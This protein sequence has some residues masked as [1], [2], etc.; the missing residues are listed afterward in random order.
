MKICR[1]ASSAEFRAAWA[2]ASVA[3]VRRRPA[4]SQATLSATSHSLRPE[5]LR[6]AAIVAAAREATA[7]AATEADET[8]L[9]ARLMALLE[10]SGGRRLAESVQVAETPATVMEPA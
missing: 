1:A 8:V 6:A 7:P 9:A 10:A 2:A 4:A 5:V 3:P